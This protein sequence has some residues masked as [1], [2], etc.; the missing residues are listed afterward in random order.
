MDAKQPGFWAPD[1]SL[2]SISG[3][4][5]WAGRM[6]SFVKP[7]RLEK[8]RRFHNRCLSFGKKR[9]RSSVWVSGHTI[10]WPGGLS[11]TEVLAGRPPWF[12]RRAGRGKALDPSQDDAQPCS[13][14]V[15]RPGPQR[16][17]PGQGTACGDSPIRREGPTGGLVPSLRFIFAT[18][19][20]G[21]LATHNVASPCGAGP[22]GGRSQCSGATLTWARKFC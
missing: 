5:L 19:L 7:T 13:A 8:I 11:W 9:T 10:Q 17:L 12:C 22:G 15:T 18:S 6:F 21:R 14:Q 2:S 16:V 20:S 3:Q 1:P 4:S